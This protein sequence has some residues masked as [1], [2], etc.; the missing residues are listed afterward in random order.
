VANIIAWASAVADSAPLHLCIDFGIVLFILEVGENLLMTAN[1][2]RHSSFSYQIFA[3][4]IRPLLKL[5]CVKTSTFREKR[6]Q[7]CMSINFFLSLWVPSHKTHTI[8]FPKT[9][10]KRRIHGVLSSLFEQIKCSMQTSPIYAR[11]AQK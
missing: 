10:N 9:K 7:A 1:K 3:M 11:T 8:S 2:V 5:L 4:Q 6:T